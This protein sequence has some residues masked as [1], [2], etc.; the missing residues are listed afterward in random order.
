MSNS[1]LIPT[2]IV[3][4]NGVVTT[5]HKKSGAPNSGLK[6][7]IPAPTARER[8]SEERAN[9]L[10]RG[11][12]LR[13]G[14]GE[15]HGIFRV[16]TTEMSIAEVEKAE[17]LLAAPVNNSEE[18]TSGRRWAVHKIL[19]QEGDKGW[20]LE[21]ATGLA[22]ETSLNSRWYLPFINTLV[23]EEGYGRRIRRYNEVSREEQMKVCGIADAIGKI[24]REYQD[25]PPP[26]AHSLD[27]GFIST[28]TKG[29]L[30]IK[31]P[32]LFKALVEHPERAS[33][34]AQMYVERWSL[35]SLNEVLEAPASIAE[36]AL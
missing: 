35:D 13:K 30:Y 23:Q 29:S 4:K 10:M 31:D 3:D 8:V 6:T 32:Y 7:N 26:T 18:R 27:G 33:Q 28:T 14:S 1:P 12:G 11:L 36:G 15:A 17:A 2:P 16:I 25:N 21:A 9:A 5:R 24:E 22:H 19:S 34:I 20:R